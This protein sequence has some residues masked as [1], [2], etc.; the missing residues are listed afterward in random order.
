MKITAEITNS[1]LK[2]NAWTVKLS[3]IWTIFEGDRLSVIAWIHLNLSFWMWKLSQDS[4]MIR[5]GTLLLWVA[6]ILDS[7]LVP[8]APY[9]SVLHVSA[10]SNSLV[11]VF[12]EQLN[13]LWIFYAL[14]IWNPMIFTF[15]VALKSG[16]SFENFVTVRTWELISTLMCQ[17][18]DF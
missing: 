17:F 3:F 10:S 2:I 12:H 18:M 9:Y 4:L 16:R 14:F 13:N 1:I 15:Y 8:W 5:D 11:L 6:Q 7:V